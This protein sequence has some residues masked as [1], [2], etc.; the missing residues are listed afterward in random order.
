MRSLMLRICILLLFAGTT[1]AQSGK[2]TLLEFNNDMVPRSIK[3][4]GNIVG[5]AH[6]KDNLGESIFFVTQTGKLA[7]KEECITSDGCYDAE[8][9]AFCYNVKNDSVSLLWKTFDYQRNCPFDLYVGLADSAVFLTDLNSNGIAEC[10]F[11]YLLSC[12]SDASPS[13]L[14]LILHEGRDKYVI[15]GTTRPD[16]TQPYDEESGKM[17]IDISFNSAESCVRNFAIEK[18]REYIDRDDFRQF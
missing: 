9:Y 7:S 15:R 17:I 11:L 16:K 10:T 13:K 3:Y 4:Y 6:W 12:R 2:I 8:I 14:K 1:N 5:G 18:F